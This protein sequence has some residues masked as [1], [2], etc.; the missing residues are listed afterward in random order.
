MKR[1]RIGFVQMSMILFV[2]IVLGSWAYL[3]IKNDDL[4]EVFN[5]RNLGFL[6]NFIQKMFGKGAKQI[7]YTDKS[8]WIEVL[9]LTV[10]TIAMSFLANGLAM[11]GTLITVVQAGVLPGAL[12]LAVHNFGVLGRLCA[13]VVEDVNVKPLQG[14]ARCGASN[15][16]IL[17]YGV[18]PMCFK[19][20]LY[21]MMFRFEVIVRSTIVV[22]A[23]GAGGLGLYFKLRMSAMDYTGVTLVI[24]CYLI[25][26]YLTDIVSGKLQ[27]MW[28]C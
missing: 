25:V 8:R 16:Q 27:K 10:D 22:G 1:K 17:M 28:N 9:K 13:E 26:V 5:E 20:F 2:V 3:I 23:V 12:A 7:A 21:Y 4:F 18:F 14:L 19:K 24:M 6:D 11:I 15:S